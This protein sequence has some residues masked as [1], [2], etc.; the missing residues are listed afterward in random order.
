MK[1]QLHPKHLPLAMLFA[2]ILGA[3]LRWILYATGVDAKNLLISNHWANI[4]LTVLTLASLGAVIC[5]AWN[6]QQAA[7]YSFNF[8]ASLPGGIGAALAGLGMLS[9]AIFSLGQGGDTLWLI[10]GVFSLFSAAAFGL[11]GFCRWKG[12]RPT[13]LAGTIICICLMLY[14]VCRYRLWSAAPQVQNYLFS[15]LATVCV[16]LSC[17]QSTA[18]AIG[19]GDRRLH[20]F[21]HLSAVYFCL[22]SLP[23]CDNP[24]LYITLA[25]WLLTDLCN[26][27]PMPKAN[28][29]M[30]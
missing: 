13:V 16:M 7:K 21:F 14:T 10:S 4:L 8:P 20:S 29:R 2:G 28:R 3:I 6:L 11:W 9:S 22:V 5:G 12:N 30:P 26:L 19:L 27:T 18:F 15:L 23:H 17:Y 25:A 1:I 24:F